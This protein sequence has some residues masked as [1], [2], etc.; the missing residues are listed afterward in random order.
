MS[1]WGRSQSDKPGGG[2]CDV[3]GERKRVIHMVISFPS[4]HSKDAVLRRPTQLKELSQAPVKKIF[5][6]FDNE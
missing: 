2:N 6:Q 4:R 3:A 1:R 5:H